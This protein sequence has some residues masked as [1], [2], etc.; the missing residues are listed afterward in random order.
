MHLV[1]L[2]VGWVIYQPNSATLLFLKIQYHNE[3]STI[4]RSIIIDEKLYCK[5]FYKETNKIQLSCHSFTDIKSLENIIH[6]VES[7][8][9]YKNDNVIS[10]STPWIQ[11]VNNAIHN[12]TDAINSL[13]PTNSMSDF[14]P[15]NNSLKIRLNF[16]LDQLKYLIVDKHARRYSILT[17]IFCLKLHGISPACYRLIQASNCVILPHE[18]KLLNLKIVLV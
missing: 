3:I 1:D 11:Q 9:I 15:E 6:E 16:L 17:Q 4:E 7:F 14:E 10:S 13:N 8:L 5:A 12:I 2:P 18:R